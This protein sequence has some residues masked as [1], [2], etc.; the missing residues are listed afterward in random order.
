V[1]WRAS[2]QRKAD[3]ETIPKSG[4]LGNPYEGFDEEAF[5]R[6]PSIFWRFAHLTFPPANPVYSQAHHFLAGLQ[7][8]GKLLRLYTQNI[9]ALETGIPPTKI[10]CVHGSW[11]KSKCLQCGWIYG[12]ESLR[13]AVEQCKVPSC[14]AC[15]G[16]I[17]LSI[18][19]FGERTK[20][21]QSQVRADSEKAD[22][23]VVIGTSLKVKPVKYLPYNFHVPAVLINRESVIYPFNAELLGEC[24]EICPAIERAL[25]WREDTRDIGEFRVHPPN[26][27]RLPSESA[28]QT[29]STSQGITSRDCFSFIR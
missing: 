6:D 16:V 3:D 10:C 8:R 21:K 11:R 25:G 22:L 7:A 26:Q 29:M 15:G 24:N 9:D 12:I 23:L 2:I 18:V 20:A 28:T 14:G 17:R 19:F 1:I 5:A 13:R 4:V 27:F